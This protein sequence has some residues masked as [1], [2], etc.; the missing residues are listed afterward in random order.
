MQKICYK[1]W[2]NEKEY[3]K[4]VNRSLWSRVKNKWKILVCLCLVSILSWFFARS[5]LI[6]AIGRSLVYEGPAEKSEILLIENFDN[7][8]L[9]FKKA[10]QLKLDGL[11]KLIIVPVQADLNSDLPEHISL[12]V[13]EVLCQE[14]GMVAPQIVTVKYK[15]P[16]SLNVARQLAHVLQTNKVQSVLIITSGFRSRRTYLVYHSVLAPLGIR[17]SCLPVFDYS[18][19]SN[20]TKSWHSMQEV[21]LQFL[22]L[23]YYRWVV[24]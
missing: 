8:Y 10:A 20:W 2:E 14:A 13:A 3:R 12:K 5:Y 11:G 7:E 23:Q 1:I 21:F 4:K 6:D 18:S 19:P 15:E 17:V 9:L 24:L 22:K 16:I